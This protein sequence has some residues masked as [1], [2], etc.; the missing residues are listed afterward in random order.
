VPAAV[1]AYSSDYT[2]QENQEPERRI[3]RG[4]AGDQGQRHGDPKEALPV[5][6]SRAARQ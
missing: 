3:Q 2:A 6:L 1:E 5:N 4:Q